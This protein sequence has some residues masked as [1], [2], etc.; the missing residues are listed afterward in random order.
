MSI[1]DDVLGGFVLDAG[2]LEELAG[3]NIY[4]AT[5]ADRAAVRGIVL[6][7][8]ATALSE[9]WQRAVR[10]DPDRRDHLRELLDSPMVV[11]APLDEDT[12]TAC[13]DL[14]IGVDQP[15]DVSAAHVVLCARDREWPVLAGDPDRI[16]R[17]EPDLSIEKL[18]GAS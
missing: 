13:G 4:A 15:P 18:P 10:V 5:F 8:P 7:V 6:I 16:R 14:M 2:A 12:A 1:E 11:V 3:A 9:S 17:I